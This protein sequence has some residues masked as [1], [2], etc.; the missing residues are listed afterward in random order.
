MRNQ[1]RS[2][3]HPMAMTMPIE[4][5]IA[6]LCVSSDIYSPPRPHAPFAALWSSL[7]SSSPA[8]RPL[9]PT[10]PKPKSKSKPASPMPAAPDTDDVFFT[11]SPTPGSPLAGASPAAPFAFLRG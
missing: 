9:R 8:A 5:D 3:E 10:K 1:P 11:R 6:A 2:A 7:G 4:P